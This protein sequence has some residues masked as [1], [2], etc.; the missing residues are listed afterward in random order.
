MTDLSPAEEAQDPSTSAQR[1]AELAASNPETQASIASHPNVYDDLLEWLHTYGT[2]EAKDAVD[3]KRG[4]TAAVEQTPTADQTADADQTKVLAGVGASDVPASV[5]EFFVSNTDAPTSGSPESDTPVVAVPA[6]SA[7]NPVS[8]KKYMTAIVLTIALG[9]YGADRFYLG[10]IGTGILKLVTAGCFG[11]W[12]VIDS[13]KI[14]NGSLRAVDELELDGFREHNGRV[15]IVVGILAGI[16]FLLLAAMIGFVIWMFAAL[17]SASG[18]YTSSSSDYSDDYG[19]SDSTAVDDGTYQDTDDG[20]S[21]DEDEFADDGEYSD[22]AVGDESG[23]QDEVPDTVVDD[24]TG[25]DDPLLAA[26][27]QYC[28]ESYEA[29]AYGETQS[30][31]FVICTDGFDLVYYGESYRLGTGITLPAYES[32]DGYEATNYDDGVTTLYSASEYSLTIT[33]QNTGNVALDET[34]TTWAEDK[35]AGY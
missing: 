7:I 23:V 19:S 31:F 26:A 2:A 18:G 10:R 3:Q 6:S 16:Y 21:S 13:I 29:Q 34:V 12:T 35:N 17:S 25:S 30:A 27:T 28:P 32:G 1:L 14:A 15:R 11:L 24:D 22:G 4:L 9:G 33:N 20:Y 5:P 8:N